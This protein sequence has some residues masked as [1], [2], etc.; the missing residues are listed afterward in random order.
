MPQRLALADTRRYADH[1]LRMLRLDRHPLGPRV[2]VLGTR[3]HE[4]HLGAAVLL[5]L[6]VG[7]LTDRLV[8]SLASGIA[9]FAGVWLVAKDW[10]DVTPS[11]RDTTEWRLGLPGRTPPLRTA[12]PADSLPPRAAPRRGGRRAGPIRS[13]AWPRWARCWPGSSTSPPP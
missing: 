5:A 7:A 3:V 13:R 2:Y 6:L 11:Q 9:A 1:G 4:W 10:R 8:L 12:P